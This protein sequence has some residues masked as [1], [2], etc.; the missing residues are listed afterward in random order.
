MHTIRTHFSVLPYPPSN[1]MPHKDKEKKGRKGEREGE[2]KG[3]R[4]RETEGEREKERD[5]AV[6]T[7]CH[8]QVSPRIHISAL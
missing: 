1:L 7:S 6:L 8:Q 4:E 5:L 2:M 3:G